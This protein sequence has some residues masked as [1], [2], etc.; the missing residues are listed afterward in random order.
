M[1]DREPSG[2]SPDITPD[3]QPAGATPGG[4]LPHSPPPAVPAPAACGP[5]HHYALEFLIAAIKKLSK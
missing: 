2:A 1:L 5:T 4:A 3:L